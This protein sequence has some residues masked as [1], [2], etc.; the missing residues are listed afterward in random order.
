MRE[1]AAVTPA[2]AH[3]PSDSRLKWERF[4]LNFKHGGKESPLEHQ[5]T[6]MNF[7]L[8][9]GSKGNRWNKCLCEMGTSERHILK[10]DQNTS[11]L[12]FFFQG[13][14]SVMAD[15][16]FF[17]HTERGRGVIIK[18]FVAPVASAEHEQ[19]LRVVL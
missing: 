6:R 8:T 11:S 1:E 18:G 3:S 16:H 19:R 4:K 5:V 7:G 15:L 14:D 12:F 9:R 13:I 10:A 17:K 2:V